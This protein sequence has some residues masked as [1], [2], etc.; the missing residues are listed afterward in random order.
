[1]TYDRQLTISVGGSRRST[2]WAQTSIQWSELVE[3][4]R[5]PI[6]GQE[7]HAAYMRMGKAQ[8]DDLKDIGGFVGGTLRNGRRK[9]GNVLG[10]DLVTLDLDAVAAGQT[11]PLLAKIGALSCASCVYSTRK[12]EPEKPRLR[13]LVPLDRTV[14]AEEYEPIARRIAEWL[15]IEQCDPT[16]FQGYRLMFWPSASA[17]SEYVFDTNDAPFLTAESVLKTYQDWHNVSEWPRVPG[18]TAEIQRAEQAEDPEAKEG[19]VGAFCTVYDVRRVMDDLIPGTYEATDIPD[20][21]TYTGG[22]TTSGAIVYGDGK[23]LYSH[24]ATDPAGG[25]LC[26]AWDL[27]RIHLYG[28]K[29]DDA[30]PGGSPSRQPSYQAMVS[31]FLPDPEVKTVMIRRQQESLHQD[32]GEAAEPDGDWM[33]G[34]EFNSRG[35]VLGTLANLKLIFEY[36]PN[37]QCIGVDTF[38]GRSLVRGALPWDS[39]TETRMW[40]DTDD[41]GAAWYVETAYQIKDLRRIKMAADMIMDAHR[42]DVLQEYLEGLVWDGVPRVDTLLERYFKADPTPY[43][44]AVCRKTLVAA[45]ARAMEPGCKFDNVLT[46]IGEQGI[47]K[48]LFAAIL[49]GEWYSDSIQTFS[50]KEAAEELRGVWIMELPEV[51]RM[52][53]KFESSLMKQFITRTD[54][55]F[56]E[57]Y[58]K[59]TTSH[60]RRCIFIASTNESKFLPDTTGN[61]RWWVVY[62]HATATD[63]GEDMASLRRDRDQIWAEAM[64]LWKVGEPL[65]LDDEL[66]QEATAIQTEAQEE[67]PWAGPIE[68]F[69]AHKVPPKWNNWTEEQRML[70]WS[71][72]FGQ[73]Q[74]TD[75]EDRTRICV[76]EVWVELMHKDMASLDKK[77]ARRI[78]A[79]LRNIP[80]WEPSNPLRTPYGAQRCFVR[81]SPP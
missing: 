74:A 52:S 30:E 36:D 46:L 59:R 12:H 37:L 15:G 35:E 61:R 41:T 19:I 51:D 6:R 56:R 45:V 25:R 44:R 7:S 68:N 78:N 43:V 77:H 73:T 60:P 16:T 75:L 4:L 67:E 32:F 8:Q 76:A 65:T 57:A 80:G 55:L 11:G 2:S 13:V 79:V 1:M 42:T 27:A 18:Q 81:Q 21:Y 10:R 38:I 66:Y 50:G 53:N 48:S 69:V 34:L 14:S 31:R 29:D 71:D 62:C 22:H 26:N 49:G 33:K 54:D 39:R 5:T 28:D 3:R 70:W 58:A 24:H 47:A 20:R 63:R 72:E 64:T 40:T 17:D 23:W 9:R